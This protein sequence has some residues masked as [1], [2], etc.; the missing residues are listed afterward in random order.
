MMKTT[1]ALPA[2]LSSARLATEAGSQRTCYG[3]AIVA[4]VLVAA[5]L[6]IGLIDPNDQ[7]LSTNDIYAFRQ[8]H[9]YFDIFSWLPQDVAS[10]AAVLDKI[11]RFVFWI[12]YYFHGAPPEL[13]QAPVFAAL[14]A[15][16]VPFRPLYGQAMVTAYLALTVVLFWSCLLRAGV[17]SVIACAAA[18]LVACS[19]MLA[20][21]SRAFGAIWLVNA[22]FCQALSLYAFLR[23]REGQG[24]WLCGLGLTHIILSDPIS[25]LIVGP[26]LVAW[27]IPDRWQGSRNWIEFGRR[28]LSLL[29]RWQIW[30]LPALAIIAVI[31]WNIV[32]A[33]Y[34]AAIPGEATLFVYPFVKYI[35]GAGQAHA[36]LFGPNDWLRVAVVSLGIWAPLGLPIVWGAGAVTGR[37][38]STDPF[39]LTWAAI[40]SVGF[41]L[42]FYVFSYQGMG[43]Q[44]MPYVG[45][46][47]YTILPFVMLLA[48]AADRI[49]SG[50]V[51]RR[52]LMTAGLAGFAALGLLTTVSYIWQKPLIP[53]SSLLAFDVP[54]MDLIGL[55]RPYYGDEAAGAAVRHV[56]TRTVTDGNNTNARLLYVRKRD[57]VRFDVFWMYAGLEYG[58]RWFELHQGGMPKIEARLLEQESNAPPAEWMLR[59]I[60]PVHRTFEG[61]TALHD[62]QGQACAARACVV[63][64]VTG[65]A[66]DNELLSR[67]AG[68]PDLQIRRDE[69]AAYNVSIIGDRSLLPALGVTD[70]RELDRNFRA[71]FPSL[72]DLIPPREPLYFLNQFKRAA[73]H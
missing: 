29:R 15:A 67:L 14:D 5:T 9:T 8:I 37:R 39:I 43:S 24:G 6:A 59:Q 11:A 12:F 52:H 10:P 26:L 13:Y 63:L 55:R 21:L 56:L 4:V 2:D 17:T 34:A 65:K 70:G 60:E 36:E 19:P 62:S 31:L 33:R 51:W 25:F 49:A 40:S 41:G 16:K 42:M 30:L 50:G 71:S 23:L 73:A 53:G 27:M 38:K 68:A 57:N 58:G 1:Q 45:Y 35:A 64:D 46:P 72:W 66:S 28:R 3:D 69:N 61:S 22:P 48:L 7:F 20:G 44:S 54:S 32:R 18:L 47:V